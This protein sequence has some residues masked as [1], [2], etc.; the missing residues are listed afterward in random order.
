[1]KSDLLATVVC[2]S[3]PEKSLA[4]LQTSGTK[5]EW[6]RQGEM[7]GHL[8]IKEIRDGSVVFTQGGKNPQEK[9][10][11]AKT[12]VKSILKSEQTVSTAPSLGS[13]SI[14]VQRP[15]L[16]GQEDAS[17]DLQPDET[18]PDSVR[19]VRPIDRTASQSRPDVS[20]RIQRVRS[21]PKQ[22]SPQEQK[23]QL[24]ETMSG[25]EEIINNQDESLSEEEREKEK[26]IWAE[27]MQL[28]KAENE[29]LNKMTETK[30][31]PEAGA[32]PEIADEPAASGPNESE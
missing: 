14:A 10:V 22:P 6:F 27:L 13:G 5:Q 17:P 29:N 9:F 31:D 28:L 3:A 20:S 26:E 18:G 11:P 30:D 8:E 1:V 16:R 7:V 24:K 15:A 25:I 4:L 12:Q 32:E 19:M 2:E 21:M 23:E